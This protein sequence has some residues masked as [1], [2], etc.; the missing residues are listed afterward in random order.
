MLIL[1]LDSCGASCAVGVWQDG[2]MLAQAREDMARGQDARLMPMVMDVM[3]QAARTFTDLDKIAVTRGP[4][5]FTGA[6]VGLATARGLGLAAHKPVIGIDR[7]AIYHAA[8][9]ATG[10]NILV[11]IESKRAELFCKFFPAQD[12]A[13]EASLLKEAQIADFIA[14]HPNTII[15]GDRIDNGEDIVKICAELAANVDMTQADYQPR[16]LYLRAPD[17]TF[18]SVKAS[19]AR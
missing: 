7:F 6:R 14:A 5:S 11:V 19:N 13:H 8:H 4:G 17:V 1:T 16:P 10:K 12:M 2:T 3:A 9:V 15:V 18:P